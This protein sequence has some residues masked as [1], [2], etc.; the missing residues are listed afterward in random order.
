MPKNVMCKKCNNLEGEWCELVVDSPD[1]DLKRDCQYFR[2]R[3]NA[4]RIR[5]MTDEE[6]AVIL[7]AFSEYFDECNRSSSEIDCNDC[8][9][10]EICGLHDGES[11]EWLRQ[12]AKED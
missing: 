8:E 4:D 1:P 10:N 6:L 7:N 9:L 3:T 5:A 2:E 11:L 12:P